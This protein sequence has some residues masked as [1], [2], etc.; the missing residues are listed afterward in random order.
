MTWI[1]GYLILG[2]LVAREIKI[3][4]GRRAAKREAI[5]ADCGRCYSGHHCDRHDDTGYE[6]A[7]MVWPLW[8]FIWP[9]A[10]VWYTVKGVAIGVAIG[11]S[12]CGQLAGKV[13][14]IIITVPPVKTV[15]MVNHWFWQDPHDRRK[16]KQVA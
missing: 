16:D 3:R 11:V 4:C 7:A 15:R 12:L 9:L 1:V 14:S 2:M 13:G 10:A 6:I 8:I 5:R